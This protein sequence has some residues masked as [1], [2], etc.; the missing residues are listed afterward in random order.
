MELRKLKK[1]DAK[2]MLQWMHDIT[3]VGDLKTDFLSKTMFD[4]EEFIEKS[5]CGS[6]LHLAVVDENDA[7]QGT[8]SLKNIRDN[9]AE[10]AIVVCK[11]AMGKGYSEWAMKQILEVGFTDYNLDE[12]YWYVDKN[13]TR[14]LKF[15]KKNHYQDVDVSEICI[16]KELTEVEKERYVWFRLTKK[17]WGERDADN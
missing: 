15:Y 9:N 4:C 6:D 13:N 8:V 16:F 14:A 7:Y 5:Q 3:V 1:I 17:E 11:D 12:I 10:F 2:R